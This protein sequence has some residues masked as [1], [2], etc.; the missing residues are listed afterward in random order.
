[1]LQPNEHKALLSLLTPFGALD[2]E[3]LFTEAQILDALAARVGQM[4]AGDPEG[5]FQLMYR[6]DVAENRIHEALQQEDPSLAVARQVYLRQLQKVHSRRLF[7]PPPAPPDEEL[8][9]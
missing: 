7:K 3:H 1:M 8:E 6:L 2:T 9:W 5:F 4:I